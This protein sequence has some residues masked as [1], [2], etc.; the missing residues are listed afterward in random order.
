MISILDDY[1]A[2]QGPSFVAI[3]AISDRNFYDRYFFS[4]YSKDGEI[5]FGFAFGR[6]PNRFVQDAHFSVAFQGRQYSLHASETL[7]GDPAVSRAGSLRV[8]IIDPMR[9]LRCVCL[10]NDEGLRC[11][12][13][14]SAETA[15]MS[16]GRLRLDKDGIEYVDQTRFMQYGRWDGWIEIDGM[17]YEFPAGSVFGLRDKSWGIRPIGEQHA[18]VNKGDQ[19]FWMNVVMRLEHTFSVIRTLRKGDGSILECTGYMVPIYPS[20]EETP[21]QECEVLEISSWSFELEFHEDTRRIVG[22]NYIIDF[23]SGAQR[24]ITGKVLTS[25]FYAGL[26]YNHNKWHHGLDHSGELLQEREDWQLA[27]VD[28]SSLERQFMASMMVFSEGE[29]IVGFGHTEQLLMGEYSPYGWDRDTYIGL[30]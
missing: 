29:T 26:G 9:V 27:D 11:D 30:R 15:P 6:Y 14:F 4:G 2:H 16:E 25:F 10:E 5:H 22:G 23:D 20:P 21:L 28:Y 13:R 3:P 19:I 8:E 17:R 1:C 24:I 12:L 18:T 7:H